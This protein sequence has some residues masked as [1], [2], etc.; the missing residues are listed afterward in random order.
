MLFYEVACL[1]SCLGSLAFIF[2][3]SQIKANK[4]LIKLYLISYIYIYIYI[5]IYTYIY[6]KFVQ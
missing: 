1:E 6:I 4:K 5:Y 3:K 2:E